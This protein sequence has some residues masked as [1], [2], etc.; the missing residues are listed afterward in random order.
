MYRKNRGE[1]KIFLGYAPGVGKTY[2]MLNEGNR[3]LARGENVWI[4]YLEDHGRKDTYNQVKNLS[5]IENKKILY[6][7]KI[8]EE[9]NI[10]EII[11]VAPDVILIDELAHTNITGSK[12]AKR[13]MDILDIL[14][15]GINV[16]TTLNLQ[17]LESLNDIIFQI[18]GVK[19]S[20][21]VPDSIIDIAT[22]VVIDLPPDSLRNRV[23]RGNVYRN[24]LII[25]SLKN[26]FRKGNLTA[27]RE[28]T[29]RQLADGVDEELEKYK[30]EHNL[31]DN[32][33]IVERIMVA[34]SSNP[35]S[36]RLIRMGAR[37]AKKYK[38]EFYCVYVSS[39]HGFAP[40]IS[41]EMLGSLNENIELA[42]KLHAQVIS[43]EGNYISSEIIQF[44]NEKHITKLILGHSQRTKFQNFFRGS[45]INKILEGVKDT[46]VIV[47]PFK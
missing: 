38:C 29:L 22:V 15:N 9:V 44:A 30:F 23:K 25:P 42:T 37:M 45:L 41:E 40:K 10:D 28:L 6:K 19:V 27:L 1:L 31:N 47:V 43:L 26:F 4:G 3:R 33:R 16:Y 8:F 36:K 34:I 21:T 2:S 20:E 5:F 7:G 17:H 13:Y 35:S 39:T 11:K 24:E 12:N 32:W 14:D 18:T 46:E